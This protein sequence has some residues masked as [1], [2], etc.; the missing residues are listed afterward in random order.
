MLVSLEVTAHTPK[1]LLHGFIPIDLNIH[2]L[3]VTYQIVFVHCYLA[4]DFEHYVTEV[5]G[6]TNRILWMFGAAV[7]KEDWENGTIKM[8]LLPT[9]PK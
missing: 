9:K 5:Q 1:D 3:Y 6:E 7:P 2:K 4:S 8:N